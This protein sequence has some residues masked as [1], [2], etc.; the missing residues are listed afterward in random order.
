MSPSPRT[1]RPASLEEVS[2]PHAS[3]SVSPVWARALGFISCGWGRGRGWI[4][5]T[6][7]QLLPEMSPRSWCGGVCS[8]RILNEV[9]GRTSLWSLTVHTG[10]LPAPWNLPASSHEQ[11]KGFRRS[12]LWASPSPTIPIITLPFPL[13]LL[14]HSVNLDV[15]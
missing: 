13:L 15:P 1:Q 2:G 11:N 12:W 8:R 3:L 14:H 9:T 6:Q 4:S 7:P 10:L 5:E